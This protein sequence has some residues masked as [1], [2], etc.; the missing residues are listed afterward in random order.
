MGL[1]LLPIAEPP[2]AEPDRRPL[3]EVIYHGR[4]WTLSLGLAS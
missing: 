3:N 2:S 4:W 1:R